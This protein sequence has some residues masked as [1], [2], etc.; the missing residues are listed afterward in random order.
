MPKKLVWIFSK[1]YIAGETIEDALKV[2]KELNAEGIKVTVDLL[3]EFIKTLT[4]P[5]KTRRH[6]LISLRLMKKIKL[7]AII[8]L[9][10]HFSVFC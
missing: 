7:T 5:E 8:P 10:P 3:G 2:S 4:K 1:K 6:I 9:S